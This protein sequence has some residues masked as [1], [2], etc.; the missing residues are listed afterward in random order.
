MNENLNILPEDWLSSGD[1]EEFSQ[2]LNEAASVRTRMKLA[3]AARRTSKRRAFLR[4]MRAKRRRSSTQLKNRARRIV[5]TELKKKLYKGNWKDLSYSQRMR[6]D[7]TVNKRKKFINN[8]VKQIMPKVVKGESERLKKLNLREEKSPAEMRIEARRRKQKQRAK[9]QEVRQMDPARLA[10]VVRDEKGKLLIVDKNSFESD[11]HTV[12]IP[13]SDMSYEVAMRISKDENFKNTLTSQR[14]LGDKVTKPKEEKEETTQKA[15]KKV[16]SAGEVRQDIGMPSAPIQDTTQIDHSMAKWVPFVALNA[17]KG[18]DPKN[19][20]KNN[21]ISNDQ[22]NQYAFSDNMKEFGDKVAANFMDSFMKMTGRNITEYDIQI[23]Q[24]QAYPTSETWK[25]FALPKDNAI[26]D[27][28]FS[29]ICTKGSKDGSACMAS[30]LAPEEQFIKFNIKY[31]NTTL[32]AGKTNNNSKAIFSTVVQKIN[33]LLLGSERN[34]FGNEISISDSDKKCLEDIVKKLNDYGNLLTNKLKMYEGNTVPQVAATTTQTDIRNQIEQNLL[35]I[36]EI[37]TETNFKLREI[38]S[39]RIAKKL[40]LHE[41]LTGSLKF[42]NSI[43]SATHM[44]TIDPETFDVKLNAISEAYIDQIIDSNLFKFD[45]NFK[46]DHCGTISEQVAFDN[47]SNNIVSQGIP[48]PESLDSLRFC[49]RDSIKVKLKENRFKY[50][51]LSKLFEQPEPTPQ[52]EIEIKVKEEQASSQDQF[53]NIYLKNY[54]SE[55]Y[56]LNKTVNKPLERYQLILN[57]FRTNVDTI[58]AS[59]INLHDVSDERDGAKVTTVYIN[60]KQRN[61]HI[62]NIPFFDSDDTKANENPMESLVYAKK[63]IAEKKARNYRR[64]YDNYHSKAKQ[65]ANRVKRV[66]ARRKL[67]KMGRVRKGDRKDVDHI[68][69]NPQDNSIKNLRVRNRS[70]NRADNGH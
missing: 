28:V 58:E 2:N 51:I 17:M 62:M 18:I 47:A 70:E 1:F 5:R 20:V 69:G 8:V 29:H 12:V 39:T 35:K 65:R 68:N 48:V 11:K 45:I 36:H 14:I 16:S 21:S 42:D 46:L 34:I 7:S 13:S 55:L 50:S 38:F 4:K 56:K 67:M 23:L 19:A 52:P 44:M 31:G 66:L 53:E 54:L 27:V 25:N 10:M 32:I 57:M 15:D 3:I 6:I 64:E 37:K 33:S 59:P 63:F 49:G 43:A 60:G 40:F 24:P 30:G 9:E 26:S 22:A 41:L 61:I